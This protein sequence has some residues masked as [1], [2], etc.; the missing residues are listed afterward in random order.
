MGRWLCILFL[1]SVTGFAL[2]QTAPKT[3]SPDSARK[4]ALEN[5]LRGFEKGKNY[6]WIK[7]QAIEVEPERCA[8]IVMMPAD[9]N[10][11]PKIVLPIPNEREIESRSDRMARVKTLP[12]CQRDER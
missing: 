1:A 6:I 4:R 5:A 11:D 12:P 2:E 3:E 10:I 9:P 7:G 8:H